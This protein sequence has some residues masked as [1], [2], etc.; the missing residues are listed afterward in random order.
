MISLII[1]MHISLPFLTP[2]H[3]QNVKL[4]IKNKDFFNMLLLIKTE[5]DALASTN[6]FSLFSIENMEIKLTFLSVSYGGISHY[7]QIDILNNVLYL[8]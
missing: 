5:T 6:K 1:L 7:L 8:C 3:W 2:G 4:M